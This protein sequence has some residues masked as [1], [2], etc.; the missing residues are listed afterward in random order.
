MKAGGI[1]KNSGTG[2]AGCGGLGSFTTGI[3]AGP[4][5]L[6]RPLYG[7]GAFVVP[8]NCWDVPGFKACSDAQFAR[9][10]VEAL[11]D[12]WTP[13]TSEYNASVE[14]KHAGKVETQCMSICNDG[15]VSPAV[16]G[17]CSSAA[18]ISSVQSQIGAAVDGQ[19]GPISQAA[20][21]KSGK[22]FKDFAPGCTGALPGAGGAVYVPPSPVV[23]GVD[24]T[25]AT[26]PAVQGTAMDF[27]TK[28]LLGVP[29]YGWMIAVGLIVG[30]GIATSNK[31]PAYGSGEDF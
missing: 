24:P 5:A 18:V 29:T 8:A 19:W 6:G 16:G 3:F 2:C 30:I 15:A 9:S 4:T 21:T 31:S 23:T 12:G 1:F 28:P 27:L 7:L 22:S 17:A 26:T 11:A 13:G 10:Q 25:K 14:N 20:L